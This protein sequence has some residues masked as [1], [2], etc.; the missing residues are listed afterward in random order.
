MR[1]AVESLQD[2]LEAAVA[3][4][5]Q[6]L[7]HIKEE[8]G[9]LQIGAVTPKNVIGGELYVHLTPGSFRRPL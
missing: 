5:R 3:G 6:R 7:Q 2:Q 1:A 4:K 9:S 8:Y